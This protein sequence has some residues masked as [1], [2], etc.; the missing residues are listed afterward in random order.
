MGAAFGEVDARLANFKHP[1]AH[2]THSWDLRV[3]AD[4]VRR[5]V[6]EQPLDSQ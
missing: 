5:H 6:H 1:A 4:T 2:R 3:G